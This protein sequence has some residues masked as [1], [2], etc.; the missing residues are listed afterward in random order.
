MSGDFSAIAVGCPLSLPVCLPHL[1]SLQR[2]LHAFGKPASHSI[3]GCSNL[4]CHAG[5]INGQHT[6]INVLHLVVMHG[7]GQLVAI[8]F[9]V[10]TALCWD[11]LSA[12]TEVNSRTGYLVSQSATEC[13]TLHRFT[14]LLA[15]VLNCNSS[16][17]LV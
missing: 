1:L 8:N 5:M 16:F 17:L 3:D 11:E 15:C 14:G 6:T 2:Q 12:T 10:P 13:M 9:T 7:K 4:V